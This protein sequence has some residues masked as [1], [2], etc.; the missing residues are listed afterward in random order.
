MFSLGR[1]L[2]IISVPGPPLRFCKQLCCLICEHILYCIPTYWVINIMVEIYIWYLVFEHRSEKGGRKKQ[3]SFAQ[4]RTLMANNTMNSGFIS[5]LF[6]SVWITGNTSITYLLDRFFKISPC[7][8]ISTID[9]SSSCS[10]LTSKSFHWN[11]ATCYGLNC[12][13]FQRS[14]L[15]SLISWTLKKFYKLLKYCPNY[16]EEIFFCFF[17]NCIPY[18]PFYSWLVGLAIYK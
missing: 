15:S 1:V 2:R 5:V 18:I 9:S 8:S 16:F 10:S 3:I 14:F 6:T 13:E 17:R 11:L 4:I 7:G 12:L